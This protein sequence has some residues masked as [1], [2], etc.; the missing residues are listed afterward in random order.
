MIR[1]FSYLCKCFKIINSK[2]EVEIFNFYMDSS[3]IDALVCPFCGA[4][5]SLKIFSS[6]KR[7]LVTYH[8]NVASDNNINISRC[9]CSSC[10]HTHAILPSIIIPYMSFSFGFTMSIIRDYLVHT[11][12]SVEA[13]CEHYGI[14]IT[15]FYRVL[16]KF[17]EHKKL[18]LGLMKDFLISHLTFIDD[19]L[20]NSFIE[21]EKFILAFFVKTSLSFLQGNVILRV[22]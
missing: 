17:K 11:F 7:H 3:Y 1:L 21:L 14:A 5:H 12:P 10:G 8:E 9:I 20:K 6:Y 2:N 18:W 16:K 19:I 15:T 13:M 4:K 22:T